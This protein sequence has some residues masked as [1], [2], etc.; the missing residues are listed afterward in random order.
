MK[1]RLRYILKCF[2]C[3]ITEA[4]FFRKRI[5]SSL[6]KELLIVHTDAIGDY[7]LFRNFIEEYRN[8]GKF[9]GYKITLCGNQVY[10]DIALNYDK[11][12]IDSFIWVNRSRFGKD[13]KYRRSLI[14]LLRSKQ[15]D[16]VI[17]PS[18]SRDF[19]YG[20]SIIRQVRSDTKIGQ[21]SDVANTYTFLRQL[22]D[23]WYTELVDTGNT[24][25]FEFNR[26]KRF[27]ETIIGG[28]IVLSKPALP[29][30]EPNL[31]KPYLL[32]FPGAGEV[33]KQ[34][35]VE[36]FASCADW[37]KAHYGIDAI[38]A[39]SNAEIE[40]GERLKKLAKKSEVSNKCGATSLI[41]LINLIQHATLLLSNDSSAVHIASCTNTPTICVGNGRH[42]GRF[43][44]Y[45]DSISSK[46]MFVFP[47]KVNEM[48]V[49]DPM[50]LERETIKHA[51]SSIN[52]IDVSMVIQHV[53]D[54]LQ[55]ENTS[56]R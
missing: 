19:L 15:Y 38:V 37:V 52:A 10:Q 34:W 36:N 55:N 11:D 40:L 30:P 6:E 54:I 48:K 35:P 14:K 7:I 26:N 42:Y 43:T 25:Q 17:N 23:N 5:N 47:P 53:S 46:L 39:G 24:V 56:S 50:G 2:L 21:V 4:V 33:Q 45:P 32:L 41:D 13:R 31:S 20:D 44:P 3:F 16:V 22:S 29:L 18:Y 27:C 28:N 9:K 12:F 8:S 49:N 1:I 51:I